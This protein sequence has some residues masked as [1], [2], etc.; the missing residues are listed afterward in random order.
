MDAGPIALSGGFAFMQ[1]SAA[2]TY[3]CGITPQGDAHCWGLGY[4]AQ[5][6][7]GV[8][9]RRP[10]AVRGGQ[11]FV[12]VSAGW[13]LT[14]GLTAEGRAYCW[15]PDSLRQFGN[16]RVGGIAAPVPMPAGIT[17]TS[18]GV[19]FLYACATA[20]DG[21]S[22]CWRDA[23]FNR[24]ATADILSSQ[25][26]RSRPGRNA[27]GST[28]LVRV[29]T[30][31]RFT[32]VSAGTYHA[33]ALTTSGAIYCWGDNRDGQLGDGTTKP[34]AVP[35]RVREPVAP[36]RERAVVASAVARP[37]GSAP[38]VAGQ[39]YFDFQ[40]DR[41]VRPA[42]GLPVPT[43][44]DSLRNLGIGG[45]VMISFVVD[46]TGLPDPTTFKVM[47]TSQPLLTDAVREV[48]P[49]LRYIP[50]EIGGSKVRQLVFQP[51]LF[52]TPARDP[53]TLPWQEQDPLPECSTRQVGDVCLSFADNYHWI[54]KDVV[55]GWDDVGE[56][57][58]KAVRV[59]H[60]EHA[61]YFHVIGTRYVATVAS[62]R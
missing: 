49:A 22:Y 45:E 2:N 26:Y 27:D 33:C 54:V 60:G 52:A 38:Y 19:G 48:F 50:A 11:K 7:N 12:T 59:A 28:A 6:I 47:K 42:A 1:L 57:Q 58:G 10:T 61:D 14:C 35:V 37:N 16:V 9:L 36:A 18:I 21:A 25:A 23:R 13:D 32:A 39:V 62:R 24:T 20:S 34:S 5:D 30:D 55:L 4:P 41:A 15:G 3:T 8:L 53:S 31:E 17:F 51:F 56:Y 29:A 44:P 46:T 40:V 43:Y